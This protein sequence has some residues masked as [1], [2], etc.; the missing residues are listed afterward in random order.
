MSLVAH[1]VEIAIFA[2]AYG[3]S[4]A[5]QFGYLEGSFSSSIADY[6]YFSFA[7]FT[8]VGFGDI[9]PVGPVRLLAGMEALTGFVLITWTASYLYIEMTRTWG[10]ED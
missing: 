2:G 1:V 5:S 8:T 9:V 4:T 6:F 7:A 10:V 3:I